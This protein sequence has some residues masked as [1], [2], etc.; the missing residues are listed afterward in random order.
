MRRHVKITRPW[1]STLLEEWW[2][3]IFGR[4][5]KENT[6]S[7]ETG[8][9]AERTERYFS[10][11]IYHYVIGQAGFSVDLRA[12]SSPL[13]C[14]LCW[15]CL[16]CKQALHLENSR[17]VTREP[18]A[19]AR[20]WARRLNLSDEKKGGRDN[21]V[22]ALFVFKGWPFEAKFHDILE[23]LQSASSHR[24]SLVLIPSQPKRSQQRHYKNPQFNHILTN[25]TSLSKR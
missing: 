7:N 10:C 3:N 6:T 24:V 9:R 19:K 12:P 8:K 25:K 18:H 2:N 13:S 23:C 22:V 1:K 16:A 17:Q 11:S 5:S 4:N 15:I 21:K 14:C 20:G